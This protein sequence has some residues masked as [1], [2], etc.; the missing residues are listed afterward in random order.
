MG[1]ELV[2]HV[3]SKGFDFLCMVR[4]LAEIEVHFVW[5]SSCLN[6]IKK[7]GMERKM[8]LW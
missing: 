1:G 7:K 2:L 6:I 8:R 3:N 5:L 4:G